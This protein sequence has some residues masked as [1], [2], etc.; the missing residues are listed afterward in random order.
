MA[1]S[2]RGRC[3]A[4]LP[5]PA[6][7]GR[8]LPVVRGM[9]AGGGGI[10]FFTLG[11]S[12]RERDL[13]GSLQG[14]GG[15][16][17]PP[18]NVINPAGRAGRTVPTAPTTGGAMDLQ[19]VEEG[20]ARCARPYRMHA[21]VGAGFRAVA[22]R[23]R[24]TDGVVLGNSRRLCRPPTASGL[25][26]PPPFRYNRH[27][28]N[29][30][31]GA[32]NKRTLLGFAICVLMVA[33]CDGKGGKEG[34]TPTVDAQDEVVAED[35][36]P[37]GGEVSEEGGGCIPWCGG[38]FHRS[39]CGDDGCGG[40]CGEC[41]EGHDCHES[42][43][44]PKVC[45]SFAEYCPG[46][47]EEAGAECGGVWSGLGNDESCEC[48][49]CP[50]G[51]EC[52]EEGVCCAYNE[53]GICVPACPEGDCSQ[54]ECMDTYGLPGGLAETCAANV[55]CLHGECWAPPYGDLK[56]CTCPCVEECPQPLQ[57][58]AA[59]DGADLFFGCFFPCEPDCESKEC[60]DDGCGGS[61]GDCPPG[62]DC[63]DEGLCGECVPDCEGKECGLDGCEGT[64]GDCPDYLQCF[65]WQCVD[66][67]LCMCDYNEAVCEP[68]EDE[69]VEVCAC[70]PDCQA[71]GSEPCGEDGYCD[72]WC[73]PGGICKDL[74]CPT[75]E[76]GECGETACACD[77][78]GGVC[79]AKEDESVEVCA[80]DPDCQAAGSEPCGEDQHCD[81]WC[82]PGGVCKDIDCPTFETE[83]CG[84]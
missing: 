4:A 30:N 56:V 7:K 42:D 26:F 66:E 44:G 55:D 34:D 32:M 36:V 2:T 18:P 40:T 23:T 68:K 43:H 15:L 17:C 38:E 11:G 33:A 81:T 22:A 39:E 13:P 74:D 78:S 53:L 35:V 82:D 80:C 77:Y 24:G 75:F 41:P 57:C 14:K 73:D 50:E 58:L 51:M 21:H 31:E 27:G 54:L 70:D 72:V 84:V 3:E 37:P 59:Q 1:P 28:R 10:G 71:P 12:A 63:D 19:L 45:F 62:S 49:D 67:Q 16:D 61:C 64:C 5:V 46:I 83:E 29:H 20:N 76:L 25:Q 9:G 69:S 52:N 65:N 60:G 8:A 47:C 6:T 48:G 79:E